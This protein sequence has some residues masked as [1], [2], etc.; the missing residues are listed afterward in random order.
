M[1]GLV[2]LSNQENIVAAD[3]CS[4]LL[5]LSSGLVRKRPLSEGQVFE[6]ALEELLHLK[7]KKLA[8]FHWYPE[9]VARPEVFDLRYTILMATQQIVEFFLMLSVLPT[10]SGPVNNDIAKSL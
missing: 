5:G 1:T 4:R 2:L 3:W 10:R 8:C 7:S 9:R 6:K